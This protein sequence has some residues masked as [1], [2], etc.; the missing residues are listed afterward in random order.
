M[1]RMKRTSPALLQ[2]AHKRLA[3]LNAITPAPDFGAGLTLTA[4]NGQIN[5][6]TTKLDNYNKMVATLDELQNEL[7]ALE[8]AL[9]ETNRRMLA[10]A[11]AH[12]GPDS[13]QY[14]QAGGKRISDRK[15]PSRKA[16][17]NPES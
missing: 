13:S 10:A 14:E 8:A 5:N 2:T 7:D 3:G 4:Y 12:Y 1:A 6:Y 9:G 15:R 16:P 17:V 11:E